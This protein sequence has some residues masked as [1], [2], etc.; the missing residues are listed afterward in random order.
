MS[1]SWIICTGSK[2]KTNYAHI[3]HNK[4][5]HEVGRYIKTHVDELMG[6]F[7]TI[8][9][10]NNLDNENIIHNILIRLKDKIQDCETVNEYNI[11]VTKITEK[12]YDI[13]D[14]TIFNDFYFRDDLSYTS[15][16]EYE[17]H[18][19]ERCRCNN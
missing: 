6:H 13:P 14:I 8:S 11:I 9:G 12:L 5:K 16:I 3:L 4:N 19:G 2:Y 15:I 1:S 17:A 7:E 10:S 18:L